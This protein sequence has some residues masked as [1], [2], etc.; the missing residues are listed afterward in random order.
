LPAPA[1][2]FSGREKMTGSDETFGDIMNPAAVVQL[3]GERLQLVRHPLDGRI[4]A[5]AHA[6]DAFA[7][8]VSLEVAGAGSAGTV[9]AP[10][11]EALHMLNRGATAFDRTTEHAREAA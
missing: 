11:D 1:N 5:F 3:A 9:I 8:A 10:R 2:I 7:F 6:D 4:V